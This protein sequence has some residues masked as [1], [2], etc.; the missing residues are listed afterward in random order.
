[1]MLQKQQS[2]SATFHHFILQVT[3]TVTSC[4]KCEKPTV[5]NQCRLY[6]TVIISL[7]VFSVI[8]G[9]FKEGDLVLNTQLVCL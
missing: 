5:M 2:Y 1:L 8:I 3:F 4:P 9:F 7:A 6:S